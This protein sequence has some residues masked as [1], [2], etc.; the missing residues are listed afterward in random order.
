MQSHLR[1]AEE[2]KI[3]FLNKTKHS[4]LMIMNY[5]LVH[6]VQQL[7]IFVLLQLPETKEKKRYI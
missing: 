7:T 1:K 2:I 3:S 4:L 6:L 5:Q